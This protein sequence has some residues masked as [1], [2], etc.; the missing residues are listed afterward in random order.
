MISYFK[1]VGV[2]MNNKII[3]FSGKQLSGKDCIAKLLLAYLPDF[4]RI[5]IGDAI[6]LEY[7]EHT[8]LSLEEIDK[9]KAIYRADLIELG[10]RRRAEDKDYW[11]K[12]VIDLPY[13]IL[14]PD[15]RMQ[16]ELEMLRSA[17]AFTIRVNSTIEARQARGPLSK[18]DDVT[19]TELDSV[20]GWDYV[21]ENNGTLEDLKAEVSKLYEY[22]QEHYLQDDIPYS[23][24]V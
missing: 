15:M 4:R 8:G 23:Q 22:L 10:Q 19:E 14:V 1:N 17:N 3:V 20:V 11:L 6:K 16:R 18:V 5:G 24:F 13:N 21:I 7:M 9:N 2:E 12:K